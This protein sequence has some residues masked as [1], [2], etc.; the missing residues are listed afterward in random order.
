MVKKI[1]KSEAPS[2]DI[3]HE[4]KKT[5][6]RISESMEAIETYFYDMEITAQQFDKDSRKGSYLYCTGQQ[7][8]LAL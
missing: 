7:G 4:S 3:R 8:V 6:D 5:I 1:V 2:C